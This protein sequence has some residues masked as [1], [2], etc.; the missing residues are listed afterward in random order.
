MAN[1]AK[2]L[3]ASHGDAAAGAK[4]AQAKIAA[5]CAPGPR[6]FLLTIVCTPSGHAWPIIR[7]LLVQRTRLMRPNR[8]IPLLSLGQGLLLTGNAMLISV[9]GL[10]GFAL[11]PN[12]A[13]ATLPV[14]CFV[15]GGALSTLPIS[16]LM[17]RHGRA[18][19]FAL[20]CV[21]AMVGALLTALAVAWGS[22]GLLCVGT[23]IF[24]L[25][26]AAG[27]YLR[28]A[29]VDLCE[30]QHRARAISLVLAGGLLGAFLGPA[31]SRWTVDLM[32]PAYMATYLTL[33][34]LAL[35]VFGVTRLL[36]FPPLPPRVDVVQ[37]SSA[38]LFRRP[39]FWLAVVASAG[40][41]A[42]MNLL[43][44]ATP[45]AMQACA[46]PFADASWALQW[47]MVGMYAPMLFSG[48]LIDR[49]GPR[50]AI[51]VGIVIIA[52]CAG[53]ALHGT[54][55]AH[56]ISALTLLGIGWA[57]MFVGGN[58][59]L[60]QQYAEHEKGMAQGIHDA[61]MFSA[62]ALSSLLAGRAVTVPGWIDLQW[63]ALGAMG[64]VLA[65]LLTLGPRVRPVAVARAS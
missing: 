61:L 30:P 17:Q 64:L 1:D 59:L 37:R 50:T 11:A 20:G 10:T 4:S 48:A 7:S 5:I 23:F 12:P 14:T 60:T 43:M 3:V 38:A 58:A 39:G 44:T 19:G 33:I 41:W 46:Y 24:G 45:L 57:L 52:A 2:G 29:A 22:F 47:H 55:V 15:L 34:V 53:I 32:A 65:L 8:A 36:R 26:N 9:N 21:A 18:A 35:L 25:Y 13:L 31:L 6:Y 40:S 56:F 27:Q 51:A 54:S 63:L 49:L 42:T 16:L 62:M 28:F